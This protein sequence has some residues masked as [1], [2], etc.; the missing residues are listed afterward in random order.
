MKVNVEID[1]TPEEARRF[2]G[3][4]DLGPVHE[5]YVARMTRFAEDGM[6]SADVE[7]AMQGWMGSVGGLADMQRAMFSA[8]T[9][10]FTG[11]AEPKD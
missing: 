4:P 8:L 1:C 7:K 5:A 10:G 9:N 2:F 11:T 6:T 3:L